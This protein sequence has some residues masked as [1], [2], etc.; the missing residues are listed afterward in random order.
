MCR[1]HAAEYQRERAHRL[2]VALRRYKVKK[3]CSDCGYRKHHAGLEFDHREGEKKTQ[4]VSILA[5]QGNVSATW[6]EVKKCDVVCGT[7]HSIRT[8]NRF[9]RLRRR[10]RMVRNRTA[11]AA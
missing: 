9:Q 11:N 10:D 1:P 6:A 3:G 2:R 4:A 8:W 7:C 5:R